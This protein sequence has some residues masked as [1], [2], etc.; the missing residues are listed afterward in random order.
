M[1]TDA[2]REC[3]RRS[4]LVGFLAPEIG[5]A[6]GRRPSV[7]PVLALPEEPLIAAVAGRRAGAAD[8]FVERFDERPA[9][10]AMAAAGV[11]ALCVHSGRYPER[12]RQLDDAPAVIYLTGGVPRLERLLGS[13]AVALVGGRR[14]T[15][16]ALHVAHDLG[17]SLAAAGVTVVSGLALGVD[18]AS[19][20]GAL[21]GGE[22]V[23]AV[24]ASGPDVPYPITNRALYERVR[25]AGSVVSELPPGRPA[26]RWAFPARNR[27]M[28]ALAEATVVVEAAERSGSLITA[29]FAAD[30]GREVGAVPGRVTSR[31]AAGSNRLLHDGAKLLRGAE[32]VL[33]L[34][35]GAGRAQNGSPRPPPA[36]EAVLDPSERRVLD[37]VE[38]G[39]DLE[40]ARAASGLGPGAVRAA[41]GR[42]EQLGLLARDGLGGYAPAGIR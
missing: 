10:A 24:L 41:L 14:A 37:A 30:L 19:H 5:R 27:L 11:E 1:S 3:L 38:A 36:P 18:A 28:A 42:L 29:G 12:L 22:R 23:I 16:Y 17:R 25:R 15:T 33:D 6:I 35:F 34:L 2:C 31:Q 26:F 13:A 21:E 8:R 4:H 7:G 40:A 9:L 20:R 32:D 39:E